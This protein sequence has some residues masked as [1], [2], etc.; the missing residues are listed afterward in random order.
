MTLLKCCCALFAIAMSVFAHAGEPK[1]LLLV[2]QGPDGHPRTTHEYMAGIEQLA[3]L[4]EATPNL[5]IRLAKADEPWSEGW[6]KRDRGLVVAAA[7]RR[8]F[9]RVQRTPLSRK[10]EDRG[11]SQADHAGRAVDAQATAAVTVG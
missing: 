3:K 6:Q 2:G 1:T 5:K 4:L 7:R 10:L 8:A 9:V 11:V